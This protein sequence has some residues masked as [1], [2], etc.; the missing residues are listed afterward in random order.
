MRFLAESIS[1]PI[2]NIAGAITAILCFFILKQTMSALSLVSVV[3]IIIG[4]VLLGVFE[5]K[6]IN[7][8]TKKIGKRFLFRNHKGN[9]TNKKHS[10]PLTFHKCKNQK[11][12]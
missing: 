5:A 9:R 12:R 6:D 1:Y 2:E 4:V 3:L 11:H 8:R 7:G 10:I